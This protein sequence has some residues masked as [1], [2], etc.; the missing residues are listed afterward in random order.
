MPSVPVKSARAKGPAP[1]ASATPTR[2]DLREA[3]WTT[4]L[5][6]LAT[7]ITVRTAEVLEH[8]HEITPIR[9]QVVRADSTGLARSA[10]VPGDDP[11]VA[12]EVLEQAGEDRG[13]A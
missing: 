1:N 13:V 2:S 4:V 7:P 6:P 5:Q 3:M 10:G 11:V 12:R 8:R 9:G